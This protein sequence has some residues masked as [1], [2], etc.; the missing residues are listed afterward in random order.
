M[1]KFLVVIQSL[2]KKADQLLA[3]YFGII[4]LFFLAQVFVWA[5][6]FSLVPIKI[7]NEREGFLFIFQLSWPAIQTLVD[8]TSNPTSHCHFRFQTLKFKYKA[9]VH[10]PGRKVK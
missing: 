1:E 10:V 9:P 8:P 2:L 7:S 6:A 5:M 3:G 4:L